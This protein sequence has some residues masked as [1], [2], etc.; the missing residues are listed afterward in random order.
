[1][2]CAPGF[3]QRPVDVWARKPSVENFIRQ[4]GQKTAQVLMR[5]HAS[6]ETPIDE[7][8]ARIPHPIIEFSNSRS[9]NGCGF[10]AAWY[11]NRAGGGI[12]RSAAGWSRAADV[13]SVTIDSW[14]GQANALA[15]T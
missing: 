13:L 7:L 15:D 10:E 6:G 11:Q 14:R 1:L 9:V 12:S 5:C 3:G 8:K 4:P 2:K